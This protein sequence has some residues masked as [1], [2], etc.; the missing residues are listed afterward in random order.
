MSVKSENKEKLDIELELP[1][2]I[3]DGVYANMGIINY[4]S[5]EFVLDFIN[6]MPGRAKARVK[7]RVILTPHHLK[8]L[9]QVIKENLDCYETNYGKIG[10]EHK[11]L[12]NFSPFKGEA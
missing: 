8:R 3:S 9:S 1:D 10:E 5:T 12:M 6:I 2:H 11:V 4:T 7:S